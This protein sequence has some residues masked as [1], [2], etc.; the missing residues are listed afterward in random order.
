MAID[1]FVLTDR[2]YEILKLIYRFHFCLGRH[3]KILTSFTG[4]R[5][6]DRRLKL[7]LEAGYTQRNKYLYGIP[8]MYT[9]SHKG[10]I[11]LN[12]NKR[13]EVIRIER[14]TH[15][16][17]VLDCAC[18]F[19][20]K[21]HINLDNV[22]T[23]KEMHSKD[24][25]GVRRHYPDMII[26]KDNETYAIEIEIALK[27]KERLFKNIKDNYLTYDNQVW[28]I[29]SAPP[30][31]NELMK[32]AQNEYPNIEIMMLKDIQEQIN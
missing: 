28:V 27:S 13:A 18:Y 30:K 17:A 6:C 23:E 3:I 16:I 4:A 19:L 8:Y 5:A 21:E 15:D 2:D 9:L 22:I 25:F 11:L 10:R 20:L 26:T 31:L 12:V 1:K 32:K 14:I 29:S 7:L 24:G